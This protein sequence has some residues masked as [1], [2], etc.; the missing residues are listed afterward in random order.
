MISPGIYR[1]PL[2]TLGRVHR[3][4]LARG[5]PGVPLRLHDDWRPHFP[6]FADAA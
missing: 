1:D 5:M 6:G 2:R 4:L 3:A